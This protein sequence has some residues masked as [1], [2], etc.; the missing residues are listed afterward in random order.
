MVGNPDADEEVDAIFQVIVRINNENYPMG[1]PMRGVGEVPVKMVIPVEILGEYERSSIPGTMAY[2]IADEV[3]VIA[4]RNGWTLR[5]RKRYIKRLE[6]LM[7]GL[8][9]Q[10]VI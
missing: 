1:V 3:M 6:K 10:G 2:L 7:E 8:M 4:G 9:N 5:N